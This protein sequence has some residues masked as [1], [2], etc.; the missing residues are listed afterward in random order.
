[1]CAQAGKAHKAAVKHT[2]K[3]GGGTQAAKPQKALSGQ[4]R[5]VLRTLNTKRIH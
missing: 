1:M 4:P 5:E 2:F 3:L